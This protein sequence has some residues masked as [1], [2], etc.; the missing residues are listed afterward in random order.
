MSEI[1]PAFLERNRRI[2][3]E[4]ERQKHDT[5]AYVYYCPVAGGNGHVENGRFI[6]HGIPEGYCYDMGLWKAAGSEG[7]APLRKVDA[8]A[9][10]ADA[11]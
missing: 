1:D 6:Q 5:R 3:A 10:P 9:A 4:M 2:D 7:P 11:G 8:V